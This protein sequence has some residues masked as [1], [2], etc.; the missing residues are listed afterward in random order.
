MDFKSLQQIWPLLQM[1]AE[2]YSPDIL[3]EWDSGY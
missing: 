1:S 3:K 2:G